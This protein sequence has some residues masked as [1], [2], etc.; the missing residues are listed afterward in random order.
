LTLTLTFAL[1][2]LNV[3]DPQVATA[4][5]DDELERLWG[6]ADG[7]I[8]T[9][10]TLE[11]PCASISSS[12]VDSQISH[13]VFSLVQGNIHVSIRALLELRNSFS[14]EVDFNWRWCCKGSGHAG[15]NE[16]RSKRIHLQLRQERSRHQRKIKGQISTVD[17]LL[18]TSWPST[19]AETRSSSWAPWRLRPLSPA[20]PLPM[21]PV[22]TN[23]S[24]L[25]VSAHPNTSSKTLVTQPMT[26][27]ICSWQCG[28]RMMLKFDANRKMLLVRIVWALCRG[29]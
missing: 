9:V 4:G 3:R 1:C 24:T 20:D 15:R 14:G 19:G 11:V 26:K 22:P 10:T 25:Y 18:Y 27:P 12:L 16:K 6:C 28:L 5:I 23:P 7:D 8:G 17:D 2:R 13:I 21:N 29:A